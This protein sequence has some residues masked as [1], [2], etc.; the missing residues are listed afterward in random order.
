M[1]WLS[2]IKQFFSKAASRPAFDERKE[3]YLP[4]EALPE[5]DPD[6]FKPGLTD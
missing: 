2:K 3:P 4:P 1:N 5:F 6:D